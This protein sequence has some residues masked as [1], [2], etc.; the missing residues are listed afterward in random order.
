MLTVLPETLT[1]PEFKLEGQVLRAVSVGQGD[2]EHSTVLH[3][4]SAAV[5]GSDVVY[6]RVH[7]IAAGTDES[8]WNA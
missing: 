8:S 7:M 6:N 4:S 3:V 2:T 5:V 1:A